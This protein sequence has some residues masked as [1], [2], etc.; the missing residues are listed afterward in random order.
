MF[1]RL[2]KLFPSLV[3]SKEVEPKSYND[4]QW[5]IMEENNIMGIAKKELTT[6]DEAL[7]AMF[8]TP[9][10]MQLPQP[11]E[12][13]KAWSDLIQTNGSQS[14]GQEV[15]AYRFVYFSIQKNRIDPNSFK[16][17]IETIFQR[18]VPILWNS[19]YQGVIVEE[20][21]QMKEETLSY[22]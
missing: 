18:Q 16:E 22:E 2:Q 5:Y 9:Y 15:K 12:Q 20:L 19:E 8:L 13:E 21:S 10:N 6:N 14:N 1:N 3:V 7:L 17:A 11:T 4:Y